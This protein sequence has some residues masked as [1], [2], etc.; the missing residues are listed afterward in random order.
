MDKLCYIGNYEH[1]GKVC[2]GN[3]VMRKLFDTEEERLEKYPGVKY[4]WDNEAYT[5]DNLKE[6]DPELLQRMQELA[7]K[8]P[9]RIQIGAVS[10]GQPLSYYINGESNVRQL[11]EGIRTDYEYFGTRPYVY[12]MSEHGMHAQIPQLIAQAGFTGAVMRTSFCMYG[13]NPEYPASCISWKGLDDDKAV[14]TVPTYPGEQ[15]HC[16]VNGF[17][18]DRRTLDF[19]FFGANTMDNKILLDYPKDAP[20]G[21]LEE[22]RDRF[23]GR[24]QNVIAFRADDPRQPEGI[25]AEYQDKPGFVW[26]LDEEILKAAGAPEMDV[27]SKVNDFQVRMP[28]GFCGNWIWEKCRSMESGL[29][30]LEMVDALRGMAGEACHRPALREAWKMLLINQHHD[31]Q[32]CGIESDARK[33]FDRGDK[34]VE[35]VREAVTGKN[36]MYR[37]NPLPWKRQDQNGEN[38]LA[39]VSQPRPRSTDC[40]CDGA[41][42]ET[43]W[44]TVELNMDGGFDSVVEKET[45]VSLFKAGR[46]SGVLTGVIEGMNCV[47]EGVWNWEAISGGMTLT[48]AGW[49]GN[50]PYSVVW[51]F[52]D[53]HPR[54]DCKV[55]IEPEQAFIGRKTNDFRDTLS[56]FIHEEKLRM[57]FYP[58]LPEFAMGWRDQPYGAAAT[59]RQSME[60]NH[61]AAITHENRGFAIFNKGVQCVAR[62]QDGALSVPVAYSGYYIWS[63][64]LTSDNSD[65]VIDNTDLGT[66]HKAQ[67]DDLYLDREYALAQQGEPARR[68][69]PQHFLSGTYTTNLAFLPFTGT[70][71]E[72]QLHRRAMEYNVPCV[73]ISGESAR[74]LRDVALRV[75]VPE[76]VFISSIYRAGEDTYIR[77]YEME[78]RT[79]EI[80]ATLDGETALLQ[81]TDFF[82]NPTAEPV[83]TVTLGSCAVR[84]YKLIRTEE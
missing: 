21:G 65:R 22:F 76:N 1:M 33:L 61:W 24:I 71:Q 55:T 49:I 44:Y 60:C 63:V 59:N 58:N 41:T 64:I 26:V 51:T 7:K 37:F 83:E 28:W 18:H 70:W 50:I 38:G 11:T 19:A 10:Y 31:I 3:D 34:A 66:I 35:T 9:G 6:E 67:G 81:E 29:Y 39:V 74:L 82:E 14:P 30:G 8:Y 75:N 68:V 2:W 80:S 57:K 5:Y 62:E 25:V 54:V 27:T 40:T 20:W 79:G 77:F 56:A 36:P 23:G 4:G 45:G 32:I 69:I 73:D 46:R 72:A 15:C 12:N 43:P 16:A 13:V 84:T 42:L 47:E 78:G 53:K 17:T 48:D 52:Y